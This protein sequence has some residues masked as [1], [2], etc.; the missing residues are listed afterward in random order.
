[1]DAGPL[2]H[3]QQQPHPRHIELSYH[4]ICRVVCLMMLLLGAG[5]V[6]DRKKSPR[7]VERNNAIVISLFIIYGYVS[8]GT[9][10]LAASEHPR[11]A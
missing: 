3:Q 1:M 4:I 7:Q 8:G 6:C 9:P 11:H 5:S 10:R 2:R